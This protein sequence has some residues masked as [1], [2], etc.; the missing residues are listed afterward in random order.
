VFGSKI[1]AQNH[2]NLEKSSTAI[3]GARFQQPRLC[4]ILPLFAFN[5]CSMIPADGESNKNKAKAMVKFDEKVK[6][7][8]REI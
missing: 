4:K 7:S 1:S 2:F 3:E 5:S 8:L 6:T